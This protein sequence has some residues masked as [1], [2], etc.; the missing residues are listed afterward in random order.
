LEGLYRLGWFLHKAHNL[1]KECETKPTI[2]G[3]EPFFVGRKFESTGS[4]VI[5]RYQYRELLRFWEDVGLLESHNIRGYMWLI[6]R[7]LSFQ[8]YVASRAL[9]EKYKGD[10]EKI[11]AFLKPYILKD[12]WKNLTASMLAQL[13]KKQ[14]RIIAEKMLS[15]CEGE[16]VFHVANLLKAASS[17]GAEIPEFVWRCIGEAIVDNC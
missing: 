10:A 9:I 16:S 6:F 11:W 17:E 13:D 14:M 8:E 15:I 1:D 12:E 2:T 7:H 3:L 4:F 5:R